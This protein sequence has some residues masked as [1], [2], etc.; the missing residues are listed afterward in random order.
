MTV[1][2]L[3]TCVCLLSAHAHTLSYPGCREPSVFICAQMLPAARDRTPSKGLQGFYISPDKKFRGGQLCGWL[4]QKHDC[5]ARMCSVFPLYCTQFTDCHPPAF[6]LM[7]ARGRQ[8]LRPSQTHA[9]VYKDRKRGDSPPL[10]LSTREEDLSS[11][12]P[13]SLPFDLISKQGVP[14]LCSLKQSRR[15]Q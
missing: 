9:V 3:E 13:G 2:A 8:L 14:C 10:S 6:F 15:G 7:V 5:A 1:V 11:C 12:G 4:I